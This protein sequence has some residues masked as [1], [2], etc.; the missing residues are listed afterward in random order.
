MVLQ[1]RLLVCGSAE[2]LLLRESNARQ[3]RGAAKRDE[4]GQGL[5][6]RLAAYVES[7]PESEYER[8]RR[9]GVLRGHSVDATHPPTRLRRACLLARQAEPAAVRVDAAAVAAITAELADAR[10][11]VA[12]SVLRG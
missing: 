12:R 4:P 6:D 8:R 7:I 2:T 3:V 1:D 9:V 11:V 10:R 5:W